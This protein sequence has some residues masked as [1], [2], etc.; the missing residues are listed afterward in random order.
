MLICINSPVE[1][2]GM[3]VTICSPIG[4]FALAASISERLRVHPNF[5]GYI[6]MTVATLLI[7]VSV[8]VVCS[9]I[10][11]VLFSSA[12]AESCIG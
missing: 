4:G 7:A 8:V 3:L 6:V 5:Q 11:Y 1:A 9:L 10:G 2:I 12:P